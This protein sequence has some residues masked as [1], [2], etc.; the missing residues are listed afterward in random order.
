MVIDP[1][2]VPEAAGLKEIERLHCALRLSEEPHVLLCINS[3]EDA[4]MLEISK[5]RVPVL[6]TV[7]TWAELVD[8]TVT[9]P[10][11]RS[12]VEIEIAGPEVFAETA[13]EAPRIAN[14][15]ASK[16]AECSRFRLVHIT[17][18]LVG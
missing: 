1:V 6:V 8:P 12:T 4:P 10:N 14:E 3:A 7:T 18:E 2:R 9:F 5:G 13:I 15:K 16:R 17:K 11:V